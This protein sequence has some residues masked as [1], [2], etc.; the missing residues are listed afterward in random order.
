VY[1]RQ[2]EFWICTD[3]QKIYWAGTHF[4]KLQ[5]FVSRLNQRLK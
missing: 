3:C 4:K 5:E 2:D 1:Q